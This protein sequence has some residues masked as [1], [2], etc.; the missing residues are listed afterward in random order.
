MR[1]HA[2]YIYCIRQNTPKKDGGLI[3]TYV[4]F[5]KELSD[6]YNI[7]FVSVFKSPDIDID[8]LKKIT[9]NHVI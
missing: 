5:V 7:V 8:A 1:S 2:Y 3:A 4:N 6:L 9:D